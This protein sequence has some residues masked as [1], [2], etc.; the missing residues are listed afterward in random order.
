MNWQT[1]VNLKEMEPGP[2]KDRLTKFWCKYK[3][4]SK[5]VTLFHAE[6]IQAPGAPPHSI[7]V[8]RIESKGKGKKTKK[9]LL[10]RIV[11][12]REQVF[13]AIDEWHCGN[14]HVGMERASTYCREQYYNCT[15]RLV[16]I[17]CVTCF[18]CM[19]KNPI[20]KSA[21]GSWEPSLSKEFHNRFQLDLID[22][23]KLRKRFPFGV[24]MRWVLMI[25]DHCIGLVYLYVLTRKHP[26]LVAYKLQD[27]F[28]SIG[29]SKIFHTDNCK[30]FTGKLILQFHCELNPNILT[31]MGRPQCHV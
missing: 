26:K 8:R 13:Y 30:E 7:D 16:R 6:E 31:V 4:G 5:W 10:G 23:C 27:F 2:E 14:G 15:Q 25:K 29:Y 11:V 19:R 12:L 21:R 17:Y 20:T 9:L 1:G 22:F 24:L 18:T 3:L 28:G